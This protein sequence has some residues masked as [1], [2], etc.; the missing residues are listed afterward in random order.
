MPRE[1][2]HR[3]ARQGKALKKA[4]AKTAAAKRKRPSGHGRRW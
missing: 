3:E 1:A 2:S 4:P